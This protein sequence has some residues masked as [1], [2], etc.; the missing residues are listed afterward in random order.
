MLTKTKRKSVVAIYKS[1]TEAEA[2]IKDFQRSGF[3]MKQLSIVALSAG[4]CVLGIPKD[5][6]GRDESALVDAKF[7]MIAHGGAAEATRA[8]DLIRETKPEETTEYPEAGV[9]KEV[10]FAVAN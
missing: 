3:D 10:Q 5:I 7:V 8:R 2:A 9:S 4:L 1:Q 6:I